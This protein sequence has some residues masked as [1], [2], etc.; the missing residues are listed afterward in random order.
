M[1]PIQIPRY[2]SSLHILDLYGVDRVICLRCVE[3]SN[4]V[5][6][7]RVAARFAGVMLGSISK[8]PDYASTVA[9]MPCYN[10]YMASVRE[11]WG[12]EILSV[13]YPLTC[14]TR[15]GYLGVAP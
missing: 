15:A 4:G 12:V 5:Y 10:Y 9:R 8:V 2:I 6:G 3:Y 11:F 1:C 7:T 14:Y 13:Y